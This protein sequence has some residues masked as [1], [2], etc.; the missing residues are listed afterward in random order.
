V[1]RAGL[2]SIVM[3]WSGP[4][5]RFVRSTMALCLDLGRARVCRELCRLWLD[6]V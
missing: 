3:G 4:G 6:S 2:R 1:M 5:T